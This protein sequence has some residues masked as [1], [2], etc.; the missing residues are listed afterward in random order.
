MTAVFILERPTPG[1]LH[2]PHGDGE[3]VGREPHSA[4]YD[5]A[6]MLPM[7]LMVFGVPESRNETYPGNCECV[8]VWRVAPLAMD[9]LRKRELLR[10]GL[11][12]ERVPVLCS[13]MGRVEFRQ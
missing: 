12:S 2:G 7:E 9:W 4:R 6:K 13:C 1:I 11:G 5:L 3:H 10:K 8:S